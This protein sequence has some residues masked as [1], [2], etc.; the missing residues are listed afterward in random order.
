[1]LAAD[2]FRVDCAA[3]LPRLYCLFV[4]EADSRCVHILGVTTNR[5]EPRTVQQIRD[6]L[7]DRVIALRTCRPPGRSPGVGLHMSARTR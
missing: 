5:D 6:L 7:M 4:M 1:M 3:N 2:F